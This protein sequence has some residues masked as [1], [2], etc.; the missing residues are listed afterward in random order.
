MGFFDIFGGGSKVERLIKAITQKF[1]PPENRQKALNQLAE[2]EEPEAIAALLRRFTIQVDPGITDREEK[3]FTYRAIVDK[4]E[5]AVEPLKAFVLNSDTGIAWGLKALNA[6]IPPPD[7]AEHCIA[8]LKKV[9]N[10][11]TR[12]PE[13]KVVLLNQLLELDDPRIGEA[14]IPFLEDPADE[15]K[16][17]TARV[18]SKTPTEAGRVALLEGLVRDQ[19]KKRV[20]SALVEAISVGKF[21]VEGYR[22]KVAPLIS[23]PFA[24]QK[25]GT[26][27]HK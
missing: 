17:G 11:Y 26:V 12:D 8:T 14:V 25:D 20:V 19:D 16:I 27:L 24:L 15:V 3:D 1:G 21:T 13:K 9:G 18:L 7:L 22:E 23:D 6:L 2:M 10:D 5:N 4:G